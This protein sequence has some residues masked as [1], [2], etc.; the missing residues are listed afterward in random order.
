[1]GFPIT[2]IAAAS[3]KEGVA[4]YRHAATSSASYAAH[5]YGHLPAA[6]APALFYRP[7]VCTV[8]RL[9]NAQQNCLADDPFGGGL[10]N[11][12][13]G[14]GAFRKSARCLIAS[15]F[16]KS[17]TASRASALPLCPRGQPGTRS[18]AAPAPPIST[19]PTHH[20]GKCDIDKVRPCRFRAPEP[21]AQGGADVRTRSGAESA[22]TGRAGPRVS[23]RKGMAWSRSENEFRRLH[24]AQ[25]NCRSCVADGKGLMPDYPPVSV[26]AAPHAGA[27]ERRRRFLMGRG[28][29]GILHFGQPPRDAQASRFIQL[30]ISPEENRP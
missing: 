22:P 14:M 10:G 18:M 2:P 19:C 29:N 28:F 27:P 26:A 6:P 25:P 13:G 1:L 7:C 8:S 21:A 11:Y 17:R 23:H 24:R 20:H 3:Q 4:L 9:A 30:D 12:R 15:P 16:C 5:A